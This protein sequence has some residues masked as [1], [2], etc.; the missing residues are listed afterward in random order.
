[1][2]DSRSAGRDVAGN[3]R[4]TRSG[5]SIEV[6][7][8]WVIVGASLLISAIAQGA[9]NILFVTLKSIA[10]DFSWPRAIP[11]TAYALLM[12]G[13]GVGGV[14]MGWWMDRRGVLY[15]VAF[16]SVMI[17]IGAWV[18]S[19]AD[20][21][22]S[23]YLANGLLIGLMGESAMIAPLIANVTKWFDRRRG[24]AVAIIASG[25]G[26][27]G[28]IWPPVVRLLN[29]TAG[30]R[31]TYA[32]FAIFSLLTM[33]PLALLLK[34]K[35][36]DTAATALDT[37]ARSRQ[38][39]LGLPASF[40][41][42]LL[43]IAVVGCC[44]AMAMPLVHLISHT[45]DLGFTST[46]AAQLF[47]VLF[48]ASFFSRIAF[49]VLADRIGGVRTM[50]IASSCQAVVLAGFAFVD[51]LTGLY[52][53]AITF[54]IG[55]AGIMPCYSLIIRL[56]FPATDAGWRI[57]TVYLFAAAGMALGGWLGGVVFDM[58]GTYSSAFLIG[59]AF[60]IM[61]LTVITSLFVRQTRLRL[62][63]LAV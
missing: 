19:R 47:S 39:V 3:G 21:E 5:Q 62:N 18:I 6:R 49:G 33:L 20:G 53:A 24:L 4:L 46:Q 51:S 9:P 27:A 63:P 37:D 60:N 30:W 25:Q 7:Y 41:Q 50:L 55:F 58:T 17:A 36:P 57:A 48:I 54:G 12:I 59:I 43:F 14:L 13:S 11:S 56:W 32:S 28:A 22:W 16:G 26:L 38:V 42:G 61:N 52:L 1:M 29:D 2:R 23:L 45:T 8:G 31:E 15:P 44:V 34:P 40:V 10:A 35:P